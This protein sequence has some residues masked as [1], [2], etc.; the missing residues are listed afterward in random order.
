MK[1]LYVDDIRKCPTGWDLAKDY[2]EALEMLDTTDYDEISLDHDLASYEPDTKEERTG[3]DI[4]RFLVERKI[5]GKYVPPIINVHSANPV[6]SKRM[7]QDIEY[8]LMNDDIIERLR[9]LKSSE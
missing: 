4:V 2:F 8:Y 7:E 9:D 5:D 6:G 1:K 3:V